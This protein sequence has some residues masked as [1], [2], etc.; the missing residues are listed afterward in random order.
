MEPWEIYRI[1]RERLI[2]LA[3][4][5]SD[6]QVA[7]P[8]APTPPWTVGDAYRHLAGVCAD[9][10]VKNFPGATMS[11]DAWTAAQI[12]SRRDLHIDAVGAEWTNAAPAL[13]EQIRAAGTAMCFLAFDAW[14]H[15]QD[16]R[17]AVGAPAIHDEPL[18]TSLAEYALATFRGFYA[19]SGAP[20]IRIVVDGD[21]YVL[22]AG[23]PNGS[24]EESPTLTLT[25]TAYELLR[26]LFGRRSAQQVRDA[27]WTGG[28][29]EAAVQA[30]HI[31][32]LQP[33]DRHD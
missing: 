13:E 17:A 29:P 27:G 25:T 6:E 7:A 10:L 4:A 1:S 8:L 26:I 18:V 9:V 14:T 30:L 21:A 12:E 16:V 2:E 33:A 15:L 19:K 23:D 3:A 32:D 22:G 11:G 24:V 20:P 5:L 31:F 28:D